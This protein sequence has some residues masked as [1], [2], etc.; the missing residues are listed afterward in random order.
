MRLFLDAHISGRV[1]ARSL[2]E[3]HGHEVR[4]A[5]EERA[6]DGWEDERLLDL[7]TVE[8]RVMVT[9]NVRDFPRIVSEWAAAG[10]RHAG[11]LIIARIDHREFGKILRLIEKALATRPEQADWRDYVAWATRRSA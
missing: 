10:R 6:L 2:R 3:Q 9:F 5:D 11:C 1:I 4:A 8:D 7:A